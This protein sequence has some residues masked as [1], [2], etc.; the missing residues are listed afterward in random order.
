M[1]YFEKA[2]VV[3][4]GAAAA[5]A[6]VRPAAAATLSLES[7]LHGHV[8]KVNIASG[9]E[10]PVLH[11]KAMRMTGTISAAE[12]VVAGMSD[13]EVTVTDFA[14]YDGIRMLSS[15]LG[16]GMSLRVTTD[17]TGTITHWLVYVR[18]PMVL[19]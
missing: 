17:V 14:P 9:G 8:G 16:F 2:P 13:L 1:R 19:A 4:P 11:T 7:G 6:P 10:P 3:L 18:T 5:L 12:A 15:A